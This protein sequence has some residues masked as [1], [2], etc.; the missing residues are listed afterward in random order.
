MQSQ[1]INDTKATPLIDTFPLS[2]LLTLQA[3]TY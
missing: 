3:F 2:L 1:Q